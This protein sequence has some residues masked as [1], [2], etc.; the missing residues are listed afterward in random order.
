MFFPGL[1][2]QDPS[3]SQFY[4]NPLYLNPALAG[5]DD[6]GRVMANYRNQWPSIDKGFTTYSVAADIY[7]NFMHGGLGLIVYNDNASGIISTLQASGIYSYHLNL[8]SNMQLNAGFELSYHQQKLYWEQ[9]IFA[10]MIDRTTGEVIPSN[11]L[12][13]APGNTNIG[14]ADFSGGLVLGI[15]KK[16]F[17]GFATHHLTQPDLAYYS[18]NDK[19]SLSRKYTFHAGAEFELKQGDYKTGRGALYMLPGILYQQQLEA[20]QLN[21]G[22]NF[23]YFPVSLGAWY[24]YNIENSDG[25]IF[26]F[27]IKYDRYRF[28]YSYDYTL[29]KLTNGSG[30]AHE[31]SLAVLI[32]C[33]K[34]RNRTGAIK[35]PEF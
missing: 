34:K 33:N 25:L 30:G 35:C 28:G 24:R 29:S 15:R 17:F 6:C 27:G 20:R 23:N 19:S 8:S 21:L 18:N 11:T 4:A 13:E 5:I 7:S 12:E 14:V 16:Y 3:F 31:V 1:K 2:A 9:L 32:A 22:L 26:Q 10:D